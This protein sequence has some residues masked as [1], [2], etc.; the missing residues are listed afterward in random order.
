MFFLNS[1]NL[2]SVFLLFFFY[3]HSSLTLF[4][5]FFFQSLCPEGSTTSK[6]FFQ[7]AFFYPSHLHFPP[8]SYQQSLATLFVG[9][10][11]IDLQEFTHFQRAH[12]CNLRYIS[13]FINFSIM[14]YLLTLLFFQKQVYGPNLF[15]NFSLD[16]LSILRSIFSS[17]P[18]G[19]TLL[20]T[21]QALV[22]VSG[23]FFVEFSNEAFVIVFFSLFLSIFIQWDSRLVSHFIYSTIVDL[24]FFQTSSPLRLHAIHPYSRLLLSRP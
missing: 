17:P 13:P 21:T 15:S 10:I 7:M 1:I 22:W 16:S 14:V 5:S 19:S 4:P 3:R 12:L 6:V 23:V 24:L 9:D 8:V 11:P 20:W 18:L 2:R